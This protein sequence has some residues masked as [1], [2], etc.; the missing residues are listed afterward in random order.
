MTL[1][2]ALTN[3]SRYRKR[4]GLSKGLR[5]CLHYA[6]VGLKK[7][8]LKPNKQNIITVNGCKL[9]IIPSDPLGTSA[10]LLLFNTHEPIS[11]KLV[12]KL[13]K[14]GMTCLDIG[15]NIG[16]YVLLESK[17]VG[18]NGKILAVE[19]SPENF[20]FL[21]KNIELQNSTNIK[22]YNFAAGD[23]EG[24]LD[25]LIYENASNSGMIIPKGTQPKWPGKIIQVPVKKI[26]NFLDELGITKI[27]FLR[28][29]VEGY[30]YHIFEGMKKTIE[31]SKP[32]IQIEVHKSIMGKDT[33]RQWFAMIKNAGYE[34]MYYIPREIDT[35]II[36]TLNDVKH[37]SI[38]EL[39]DMLKKNT[40]PSFFMLSLIN[41]N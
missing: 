39:E 10:E 25:F 40:L 27:D 14:K 30:E 41:K 21:K 17:I 26:D 6:Y 29:D 24:N 23:T 12:T 19:P 34:V 4:Y 16:Y 13:L 20:S 8:W 5:A 35:P 2:H 1:S 31:K 11:T 7:P 33:T 32:I 18:D 36:G 15:A 28:M 22:A 9:E 37:Y 3:I 38:N